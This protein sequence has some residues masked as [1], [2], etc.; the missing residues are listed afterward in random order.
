LSTILLLLPCKGRT[1]Y[2]QCKCIVD[3]AFCLCTAMLK[4][5]EKKHFS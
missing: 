5:K 3:T 1:P 2:L 4:E